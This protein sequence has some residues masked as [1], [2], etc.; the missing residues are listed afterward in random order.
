[1]RIVKIELQNI[2]SLKSDQVIAIDFERAEFRDV[3][4]FAITGS[5]GAGKTSILDAITIALYHRVPRFNQSNIKAGLE[6]I[7]SYGASSALVNLTF[8]NKGKRYEAHWSMRIKSKNGKRLSNSLE[9]VRIKDLSEGRIL[10][11][12]KREVAAKIEEI[13]QLNYKQFL[14]SVMLAQGE[15]AAF[16]SAGAK[17]KGNLLEQITGEEIYKIIGEKV[18]QRKEKEKAELEKLKQKIN[19]E[20]LLDEEQSKIL[21]V[22]KNNLVEL[23][24]NIEKKISKNHTIIRWYERQQTLKQKQNQLTERRESIKRWKKQNESIINKLLLHK[25]AEPY[26]LLLQ[27]IN[28]LEKE[29]SNL[30]T[31]DKKNNSHLKE[32]KSE[33][34]KAIE[35]KDKSQSKLEKTNQIFRQWQPKLEK[36]THWDT[37][38]ENLKSK[39]QEIEDHLRIIQK[40]KI[41]NTDKIHDLQQKHKELKA[42]ILSLEQNLKQNHTIPEIEKHFTN[43]NIHFSNSRKLIQDAQTEQKIMERNI[44]QLAQIK[45]NLST[46]KETY[47]REY[48]SFEEINNKI[49]KIESQIHNK[50]LQTLMES[51]SKYEKQS[52]NLAELLQISKQYVEIKQ[53]LE[54]AKSQS[55]TLLVDMNSLQKSLK[56]ILNEQNIATQMLQDSR[57]KLLLQ[58][59]IVSLEEERKKLQKG[60]ACPLCGST[61]HPAIREYSEIKIPEIQKEYDQREKNLHR[62]E[63]QRNQLKIKIAKNKTTTQTLEKQIAHLNDRLQSKKK[64][65]RE[66]TSDFQI[67]QTADIQAK[68]Q[69]LQQKLIVLSKEIKE[70]QQLQIQKENLQK[71]SAQQS[72]QLNKQ[73][74]TI[75]K[76][77]EKYKLLHQQINEQKQ[78]TKQY[79]KQAATVYDELKSEM[80]LYRLSLPDL[81]H[82]GDYF[83][84][85]KEQISHYKQRKE[86]LV[87]ANNK[88]Q[89]NTIELRNLQE[90]QANNDQDLRDKQQKHKIL[91]NDLNHLLQQRNSTLDIGV[92][93]ADKRKEL[94]DILDQ[95]NKI[96]QQQLEEVNNLEKQQTGKETELSS[97]REALTQKNQ[98]KDQKQMLLETEVQNSVFESVEA[99]KSALLSREQAEEYAQIQKKNENEELEI[100]TLLNSIQSETQ[101]LNEEKDFDITWDEVRQKQQELS[102]QKN[103]TQKRIG[104]IEHRFASNEIILKRNLKIVK[105]I[106]RQE[107]ESHKWQQLFKLLGN[108]KHAF[109]TYVQRLSLIELI[110]LANGHLSKLNPRY[111]LKINE[112]YKPGEELTFT[113]IDHYQTDE[114]RPVETA[115]GGEKFLISLALALGLSDLASRNV[116][117]ES[118]FI[119]E[120]FGTLDQHSLEIVIATLETLQSQGKIIGIISHVE[121]LK[122][123]ITTQIQV[124]KQSNGVSHIKI[125]A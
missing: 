12:K 52:S 31:Q 36:L 93:V 102:N 70:T 111:S 69:E 86:Q 92:T 32:L 55:K 118:L 66:I 22:E 35:N 33:W 56:T 19:T 39:Q 107:K 67:E 30:Q 104:E 5:T 124:L 28:N 8:E 14:R 41:A 11:E 50:N 44:E 122:E 103:E 4:L 47:R 38:I 42:Q 90:N 61:I 88:L 119:D 112:K 24:A 26:L 2:N 84:T 121:N 21:E 79:A 94:Q 34:M 6:D 78:K 60:E 7:I 45:H 51:Q 101:K 89:Q 57:Q 120:G 76:L 98:L 115:S 74:S 95:A 1:M 82:S 3:G 85:L 25:K 71:S 48:S 109:N 23:S 116:K 29:V 123:R 49:E 53:E 46:K 117:V 100:N 20:D 77:H 125:I 114:A 87:Q 110:R 62:I 13:I 81:S 63:K 72:T 91:I 10:A 17:E 83:N 65:F 108:S 16:L 27:E 73:H 113:L 75:V 58:K 99:M 97:I 68:R 37:Q 64:N 106:R 9:E 18:Q 96:Y 80:S 15:F 43:W 40:N 54:S 59:K 105:D